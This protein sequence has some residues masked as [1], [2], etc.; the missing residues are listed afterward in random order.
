MTT[1]VYEYV[2]FL[3]DSLEIAIDKRDALRDAGWEKDNQRPF[4]LFGWQY[5]FGMRRVVGSEYPPV[6]LTPAERMAKARASRGKNK[7]AEVVAE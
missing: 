2:D 6:K 3:E 1:P 4:I 5:A 7:E